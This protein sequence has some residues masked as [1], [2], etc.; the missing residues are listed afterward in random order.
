MK[1]LDGPAK[2][3]SCSEAQAAELDYY[4]TLKEFHEFAKTHTA[5]RFSKKAA[6]QAAEEKLANAEQVE[7]EVIQ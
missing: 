2:F 3:E 7:C 1:R 6:E 4:A 5:Y